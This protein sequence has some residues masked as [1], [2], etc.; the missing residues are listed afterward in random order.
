M[1]PSM[2]TAITHLE[3]SKCGEKYSHA[4]L[5]NLCQCGGPLLARYDLAKAARTLTRE[6]LRSRA[7]NMWRYAEVLPAR[8]VVSLGEGM[9]PV[10]R[11]RRLGARMGLEALYVKDEGLNPTGSFKARGLSAAV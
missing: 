7:A 10:I 5:Q 9:T 8:E 1:N 11:A 4:K 2:P 3:C 6:A